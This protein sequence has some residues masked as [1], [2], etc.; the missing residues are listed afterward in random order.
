MV[1]DGEGIYKDTGCKLYPKC[2]ECPFPDCIADRL[3][4]LLKEGKRI[5]AIQMMAKEMAATRISSIACCNVAS[6]RLAE[7]PKMPFS[8]MLRRC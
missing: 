1:K 5:E 3:P 6:A 7:H 4:S 2:L 8:Y